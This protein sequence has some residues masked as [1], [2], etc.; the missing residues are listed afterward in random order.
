MLCISASYYPLQG[1]LCNINYS[2]LLGTE[3]LLE[4][5]YSAVFMECSISRR[6]F[7]I[8]G[9]VQNK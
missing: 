7:V 9:W 5:P 2:D 8:V 6:M 3:N 4:C 1:D